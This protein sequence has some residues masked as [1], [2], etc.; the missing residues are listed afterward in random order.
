[1]NTLTDRVE[2]LLRE[3]ITV[4]SIPAASRLRM[5]DL[6]ARYKTG[7][8]PIREALTRLAADGL[9]EL[10][11]N[12]GFK[13]ARLSRDDLADIAQTRSAIEQAAIRLSIARGDDEWEAGIIGALHRYRLASRRMGDGDEQLRAWEV[14]HDRLHRSFFAACG[15]MRMLKFLEQLQTQHK[16]Y[17]RL[18]T[19]FMPCEI[20][21]HVGEHT[22][23]AEAVLSRDADTAA[24]EVHQHMMITVDVLDKAKVWA[25]DSSG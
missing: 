20:D 19:R 11:S 2:I 8:S 24:L 21:T 22:A 18:L 17:R 14:S 9:V 1:M 4:G 6:C 7:M 5:E 25:A 10:E 12:K 15:S 13:V 3:H 16:R 23:L